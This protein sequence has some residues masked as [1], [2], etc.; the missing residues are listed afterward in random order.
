[1][2]LTATNL[3]RHK[4]LRAY[5]NSKEGYLAT[6]YGFP[7]DNELIS[8]E[9]CKCRQDKENK[10]IWWIEAHPERKGETECYNLEKIPI[11]LS[12]LDWSPNIPRGPIYLH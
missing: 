7:P 4:T 11:H 1:M 2:N 6:A 10:D 8:V 12:I 5:I 3:R 9:I